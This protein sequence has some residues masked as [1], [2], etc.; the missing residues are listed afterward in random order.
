MGFCM[1]V[2]FYD[3]LFIPDTIA[4]SLCGRTC[5]WLDEVAALHHPPVQLQLETCLDFIKQLEYHKKNF[6]KSAV[7]TFRR[8]TM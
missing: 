4:I 7:E 6:S 1:N 3:L 2:A 5:V 8:G